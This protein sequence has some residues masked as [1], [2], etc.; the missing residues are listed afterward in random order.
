MFEQLQQMQQ[1]VV[2]AAQALA[3]KGDA[4]VLQAVQEMGLGVEEQASVDTGG[5]VYMEK[6]NDA[7]KNIQRA[8]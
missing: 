3:E 8:I 4:R 1:L 7:D 2:M 5:E 6:V